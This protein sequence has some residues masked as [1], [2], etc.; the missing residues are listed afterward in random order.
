MD[1]LQSFLRVWNTRLEASLR[2]LNLTLTEFDLSALLLLDFRIKAS[3]NGV[4][5]KN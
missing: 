2:L 4:I 3:R 5:C 1:D